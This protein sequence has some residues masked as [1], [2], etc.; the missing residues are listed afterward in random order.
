MTVQRDSEDRNLSKDQAASDGVE[1]KVW[2]KGAAAKW[3]MNGEDPRL[4]RG[5]F[6]CGDS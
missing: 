2:K 3:S 6:G 1:V 5:V 4:I